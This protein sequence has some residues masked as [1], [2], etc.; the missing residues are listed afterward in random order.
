MLR[1]RSRSRLAEPRPRRASWAW[2]VCLILLLGLASA[3]ALAAGPRVTGKV[4]NFTE[5]RNPVWEEAKNPDR[6]LYSFREVV[7]TVP[8]KERVLYPHIPKEVCIAALSKSKQPAPRGAT[9]IRVGGGRTTPVT[10]VVRPQAR[11]RFKNTDPFKHRLYV[12]GSKTFVAGDTVK[13]GTRDWT[14]PA[15]GSYEVRDELAPSLRMWIVAENDVAEIAY[16]NLKGEFALRL[17]EDGEYSIQAY[18]AGKKVGD[19][20]PITITN[21]RDVNIAHQPIKL[22][23]NPEKSKKK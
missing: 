20:R 5:L 17:E 18:F 8:A 3:P 4:T 21:G 11:L 15:P 22:A 19:P 14:V 12:V 13:G 7:P 10:L 6:H 2:P 1:T 9:L 23:P 16:P